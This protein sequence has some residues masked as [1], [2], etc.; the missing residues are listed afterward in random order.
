MVYTSI[1]SS[2][3]RSQH[4]QAP[5]PICKPLGHVAALWKFRRNRREPCWKLR[6]K[7]REGTQLSVFAVINLWRSGSSARS[8]SERA[9][10]Y[11]AIKQNMT[12]LPILLARHGV[13]GNEIATFS[14][15]ISMS[16]KVR[17]HLRSKHSTLPQQRDSDLVGWVYSAMG[18]NTSL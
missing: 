9:L 2:L 10:W 3:A 17:G 13:S 4:R 1:Y 14:P 12:N 8:V 7:G 18:T 15:P 6:S 5:P 16:K 11:H